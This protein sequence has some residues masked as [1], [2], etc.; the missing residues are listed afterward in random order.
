M[1]ESYFVTSNS[2][3]PRSEAP[4]QFWSPQE[5]VNHGNMYAWSWDWELQA[6]EMDPVDDWNVIVDNKTDIEYYVHVIVGLS[7]HLKVKHGH[8]NP[9]CFGWIGWPWPLFS[10]PYQTRQISKPTY[11]AIFTTFTLYQDH[12]YKIRWRMTPFT[13]KFEQK[14]EF[15]PSQNEGWRHL[16][17]C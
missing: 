15:R 17:K 10:L 11:T 8:I 9:A 6:L 5:L 16:S 4:G 7:V 2:H 14:L 3:S 1:Y 13:A 12:L